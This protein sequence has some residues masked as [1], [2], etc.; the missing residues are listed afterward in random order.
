MLNCEYRTW[1]SLC[2]T[3]QHRPPGQP[4]DTSTNGIRILASDCDGPTPQNI[5][6]RHWAEAS[7]E[8]NINY[9]PW[10]KLSKKHSFPLSSGFMV[11]RSSDI[12]AFLVQTCTNTG[13]CR[14]SK[15]HLSVRRQSGTLSHLDGAASLSTITSQK[16]LVRN[17]KEMQQLRFIE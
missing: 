11:V 4:A 9:G 3:M 12:H 10:L 6:I 13:I 2:H 7:V 8:F 5:G 14:N 16:G 17:A 15:S 1:V